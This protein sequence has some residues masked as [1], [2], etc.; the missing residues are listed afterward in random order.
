[1]VTKRLLDSI[2][3]YAFPEIPM[4]AFA[5]EIIPIE[6]VLLAKTNDAE[7]ALCLPF[8]QRPPFRATTAVLI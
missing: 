3:T 2:E 7:S 1:M 6:V 5:I 8:N 4:A